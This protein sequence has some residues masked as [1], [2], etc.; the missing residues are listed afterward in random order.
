MGSINRY[1]CRAT[2][3]AFVVVLVSLTALMWVTQAL[4]DLDLVTAQ[5]QTIFTFIGIT[6]LIVPLLV[7]VIA[8]IALMIA[9]A[10]VLNRLSADSE[11]IVMNATGMSPWRLFTPF[12][13]TAIT[14][15]LLIGIVGAY[16][17]PQGLRELRD[18]L[19]QVRTDLVTHIVKP[20][21]FTT[22]EKGL[23]LHIRE[24][25]ISGQLV[26]IL[27][28]DRRDP[29][30]HVTLIAEEGEILKDERGTF[31]LLQNGSVQRHEQSQRDPSI[32]LF[33]RYAFDLSRFNSGAPNI[34]YSVRERYLWQLISPA[35]D[36]ALAK[37]QAG[38]FR[39]EM[40]DRLVAPL[41]PIAFVIITY[42]FLGAPRTTRQSRGLS[43]AAA[44]GLVA[45]L[46]L[47]GFASTVVGVHMPLMLAL[48][49]VAVAAAIGF[50]LVAISRGMIIEPPAWVTQVATLLTERL[51]KRTGKVAPA[52]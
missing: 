43:L 40:H 8:P 7:L 41:Y 12:L 39:A 51:A 47:I 44:I 27:I 20:G 37:S 19:T 28:D 42:A 23:T 2:F 29:L 22:I 4:R 10:F 49:Y 13:L 25:R 50:G 21:R 33:D 5:R 30:E 32:V 6:A 15:A 18:W 31:L 16:L 17:A 3:G 24:R 34:S 35:A 48:Q 52:Q 11:I 26:G 45:S 38:Q 9:V 1:I 14:V 46:R 36:D